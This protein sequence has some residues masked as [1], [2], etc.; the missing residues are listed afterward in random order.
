MREKYTIFLKERV[1]HLATRNQDIWNSHGSL[2]LNNGKLI[3]YFLKPE[4]V[5][6][7]DE[8]HLSIYVCLHE[9][10]ISHFYTECV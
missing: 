2:T 7:F 5:S 4:L 6:Y 9:R 10:T 8:Y 3:S 1:Y